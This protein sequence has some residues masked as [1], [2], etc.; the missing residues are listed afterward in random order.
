MQFYY[1][2][3]NDL[4]LFQVRETAK[5]KAI[6]FR[7]AQAIERKAIMEYCDNRRSETL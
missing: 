1:L 7:K 6:K 2:F 3:K 5:L 4:S